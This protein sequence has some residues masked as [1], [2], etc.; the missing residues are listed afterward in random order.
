M[1]TLDVTGIPQLDAF[2]RELDEA[3]RGKQHAYFALLGLKAREA[4]SLHSRV[5]EG[6]SYA[7]LERLQR[8]LDMPTSRLSEVLRIPART[9]ARRRSAKRLQPDES[10][11]LVRLARLVGLTLRLFE[12]DV[13]E[14]RRWLGTR[15]RSLG[16]RAPLEFASSEVGMREVENLIGRLEQGIPL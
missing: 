1:K 7:A 14:A 13:A 6:L 10:D 16:D 12:G 9:L 5:E 8:V 2:Q 4:G 11:R 3:W 15:Q